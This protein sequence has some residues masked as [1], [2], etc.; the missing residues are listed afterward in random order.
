MNAVNA[1]SS[2]H[3]TEFV[4][5]DLLNL[6]SK[7]GPARKTRA[8]PAFLAQSHQVRRKL[9]SGPLKVKTCSHGCVSP[10]TVGPGVAPGSSEETHHD[11]ACDLSPTRHCMIACPTYAQSVPSEISTPTSNGIA[12]SPQSSLYSIYTIISCF[13]HVASHLYCIYLVVP[14]YILISTYINPFRP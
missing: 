7:H 12:C 13:K 9:G 10:Y 2:Q 5:C 8:M 3:L 11:T 6:L 14:S 4:G 1:F